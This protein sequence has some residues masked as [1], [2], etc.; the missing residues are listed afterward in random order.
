MPDPSSQIAPLLTAAAMREADRVTIEE[1]GIPGHT[2]MECAGRAAT[3]LI[4]SLDPRR[5]TVVCGTGNNGGDGLVV[6][7]LLA[8]RGV[9][10]DVLLTG[11]MSGPDAVLNL[12]VLE[13]AL[14]RWPDMPVQILRPDSVA[15]G[16][17]VTDAA[18]ASLQGSDV[19]VD[20]L[21]GTGL[22]SAVREPAAAL[23]DGMNAL[24]TIR[25]ALDMPSGLS[26]DT[27]E[28]QGRAVHAHHTVTFGA[29]KVGL[30]IGDGPEVAGRIHVADIGIPRAL[31]RAAA[32]AP[33]CAGMPSATAVRAHLRPRRRGDHKYTTGPT[34][35]AG[36]STA[37]PGAPALAALAAARVGS[38]Y[39]TVWCPEAIRPL[40]LEKLT[41][42]PVVPFSEQPDWE[43]A[44]ALVVGPGLGRGDATR[45]FVK[46]TLS[47]FDGPAVVDADA[48]H[49]LRDDREWVAANSRARWVFTPHAGEFAR[50]T[51][52]PER[53]M[54]DI[55]TNVIES[56]RA[57]A[58]DWNVVLL[59]KGQPSLTAEPDGTV[60]VNDTGNASAGTAGTGDV[61]AGMIGGLLATGIDPFHAA[62]SGIHLAGTAADRFV[63]EGASQSMMA[64]DIVALLP[65]LLASYR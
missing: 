31:L 52:T 17:E 60:H 53:K 2:L 59:L 49:A 38:G 54:G 14:E 20:A 9:T 63:E 64:T 46:T 12:Q 45:D 48:L 61:L 36:G 26:S 27:G 10:V 55:T 41:E 13:R 7:R 62:S 24:N 33:G 42:I 58:R 22:S 11:A 56:V 30:Y 40:L 65:T 39:V 32:S 8:D 29:A 3:A 19:V 43:R 37:F 57:F 4:R 16:G 44:R 1:I 51:G 25:I 28:I 5:V 6:A 35:V 23:I 34:I 50:L 18:W 15:P 21:L 47:G